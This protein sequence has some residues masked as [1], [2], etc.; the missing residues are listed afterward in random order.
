M[1]RNSSP[2]S[3]P[4]ASTP[5]SA[6]AS[7]LASFKIVGDLRRF[8]AVTGG[9]IALA[10]AA[11]LATGG[12]GG[13]TATTMP[14]AAAPTPAQSGSAAAPPGTRAS[15]PAAPEV[16]APAH[17]VLVVMENHSYGDIIENPAAPFINGIARRGALFTQSF[18][19]THPS[20]PNYLALFSGSTH[21]VTDDSCPHAYGAPNLASDLAAAGRSFTGYAEGL[22][23]PDAT[24]CASGDYA[25]KHVPWADFVGVPASDSQPFSR[26]P[27]ADPAALPT[28]SMVIPD[29]CHDMHDCGVATGDAWLADHLGG[30]A[31]WAMTHRGLLIITWDEDDTGAGNHIATIFFGQ[32]VKPGR[33]GGRI[34]HYNVLA[35]I[36]QAYHLWR[37]GKAAS[38]GPITGIWAGGH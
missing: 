35:T 17:I 9:A 20:E 13:S 27:A 38:A 8:R 31:K 32:L 6:L 1:T 37:D 36:E 24:V 16:P 34:T 22:P 23:N 3:P 14:S 15:S 10:C 33:Y 11:V 25:R 5:R 29:L 21:G 2:V 28:V 7:T 19:V 30:Y 26:F 4:L 18:A 12:C